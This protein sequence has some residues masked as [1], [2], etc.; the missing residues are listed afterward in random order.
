MSH[1]AY[2]YNFKTM[3]RVVNM[4]RVYSSTAAGP[5]VCRVKD[6]LSLF[7]I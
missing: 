3:L 5:R 6:C 1:S 7:L 4:N 2:R